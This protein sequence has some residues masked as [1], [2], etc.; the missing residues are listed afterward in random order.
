M[1]KYNTSKS[2]EPEVLK[3]L[4]TVQLEMLNDFIRVCDKHDLTYF[5][6]YGTAIGAVRHQGFIP[7]DDDIDVAMLRRDYDKFCRIF[8][9]ELSE[10]YNLL[11]PIID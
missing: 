3:K 11:T 5:V 9:E 10:K 4:H 8:N 1:K 7:W 6:V 2:Y